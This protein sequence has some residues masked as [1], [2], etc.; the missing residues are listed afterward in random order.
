MSVRQCTAA[1]GR[2]AEAIAANGPVS[3]VIAVPGARGVI[4]PAETLAA[5]LGSPLHE[6]EPSTVPPTGLAPAA[7]SSPELPQLVQGRVLVFAERPSCVALTQ[8]AGHLRHRLAPDAVLETAALV[9]RSRF[10][11]LPNWWA[12]S[13]ADAHVIFPW[14]CVEPGASA[15]ALPD[16]Q[17]VR[18][19]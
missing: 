7:C 9:L 14:E 10:G 16:F 19:S 17:E 6:T 8:T 3:A 12:W 11:P 13:I 18:S 1:L 2:L 5:Y 15:P 4:T